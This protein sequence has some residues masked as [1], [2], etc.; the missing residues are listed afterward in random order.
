MYYGPRF[1]VLIFCAFFWGLHGVNGDVIQ[2]L[3]H[4]V[5]QVGALLGGLGVPGVPAGP[6]AG[7]PAGLPPGLAA[8]PPVGPLIGPFAGPPVCA[9]Q[10]GS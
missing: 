3:N 5:P 1:T 9:V 10:V 7:L 2:Q 4:A 6:P 8:G